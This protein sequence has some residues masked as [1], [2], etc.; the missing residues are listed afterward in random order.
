MLHTLNMGCSFI[1]L[2]ESWN[3]QRPIQNV[4]VIVHGFMLLIIYI[5][6]FRVQRLNLK[7]VVEI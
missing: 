7:T 6:L 1:T 3:N 5:T 4:D 2:K